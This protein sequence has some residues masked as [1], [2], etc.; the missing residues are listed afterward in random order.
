MPRRDALVL[1]AV[2]GVGVFLAG[3]ELMI[4]AV[5]L[6]AIVVDLADWT[7]LRE[8]SWI[9]NGYLLVYVVTMP[10]AGRLADLWGDRRLF[11]CA[12]ALFTVG[13]FLAGMAPTLELL[14]VARLVQAVGGGV[15]VPVATS[16]ASHLFT[17]GSRPR[18]LGVI[19]ALTFLGMAAGPFVGAA[20]LGSFHPEVALSRL[21]IPPRARSPGCSRRRGAGCST[22]T[23]RSASIV[24]AVVVGRER[25]LGDAAPRGP[26]WTSWAPR[27]SRCSSLGVARL[28]H[29][30]RRT[31]P[32]RPAAST[33]PSLSAVARRRSRSLGA[34]RHD[35]PRPRACATRS[36]TRACSGVASF[37]SA[38]LVSGAHRL[39]LRDGDRRR[40]GVRRPGALRRARRAA[41]RAG[42]AGRRDG[43]RR[44]RVG[45]RGAAAVAAAR[46]AGRASGRRSSRCVVMAGWTPDDQRGAGRGRAG[47]V[48]RGLRPDRDA[49]LHR[50]GRG[51]RARG[52][53]H[54]VVDRDRRADGRAWPSA[55]RSSPPT[56]RRPSTASTT[57]STRRRT[58]TSSSSPRR[59]R[60]GRCATRLVVE[61]LEAWAAGEAARI[62]VGVFLV[63][64]VVTAAAVPPSLLLDRRRRMLA[65]AGHGRAAPS[66]SGAPEPDGRTDTPSSA[67]AADRS[68]D[69]GDAGPRIR[70]VACERRDDAGPRGH[71]R[72][73]RDPRGPRGARS[74]ST[75]TRVSRPRHRRGREA[76]RAPPA[77]RRGHRRAQPAG[78]GRGGRGHDPRR[79]VLDRVR[80]RGH[81]ARGGPRA[82]PAARCSP[83]TSPAWDPFALPQ[84]RGDVG[85]VLKR[86]PDFLLYAITD[87]IV[88]GYFPVFDALDDEIDALQ[89]DVI[90]EADHVD[91]G[92]AVRAQARA[93]P[94]ASGDVAGARDLQPAHEPR[95]GAR[96]SRS[97]SSTSATCTTT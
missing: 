67:E 33:P 95:P 68:A 48:R 53:R 9:I 36:S 5:A 43:R 39:R 85:H 10:L 50:R 82:R 66:A 92:A 63:A 60:T 34:R 35:R 46:D 64:A 24:L 4:T 69:A 13:S 40:G 96:R 14:V 8:A 57:A 37:S 19:G 54:R 32:R 21:G 80:G 97:T 76:A 65:P 52:V 72:A 49:A 29:A 84:L 86:G 56:A 42:G 87:G 71:G 12:L 47:R 38:T 70:V 44:A 55:S 22:S 6:P 25:G 90:A 27:C 31:R 18:A 17:G 3:M 61:A 51:G 41:P 45:L 11:L 15:L 58:P 88:D 83:S 79:H 30:A 91:A 7:R 74:G 62:M 26:A 20:I 94:A 78:E 1:L 93:D 75:S 2:L 23:S 73:A 81:R 16:A 28:A 89:D 59:C 77:H